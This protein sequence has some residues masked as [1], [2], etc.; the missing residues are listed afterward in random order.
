[1]RSIEY[2]LY[3]KFLEHGL[4]PNRDTYVGNPAGYALKQTEIKER[5]GFC[6]EV[7]GHGSAADRNTKFVPRVVITGQG[8]F[9]GSLGNDGIAGYERNKKGTYDKIQGPIKSANYR[10][11]V[12][13]ISNKASQDNVLEAVRADAVPDLNYVPVYN[14]P[15]D[16]FLVQYGGIRNIPDFNYGLIR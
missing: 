8:F 6:V 10:F 11:E 15:G 4:L 5:K 1:M 7:F 3:S 9:A 16:S 2:A 12:E 14:L 13:L